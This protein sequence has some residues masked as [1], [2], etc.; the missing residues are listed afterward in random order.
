[1]RLICLSLAN[2]QLSEFFATN[3]GSAILLHFIQ[4]SAYCW[5]DHAL[6][7]IKEQLLTTLFRSTN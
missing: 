6:S 4:V 1:M 7:C 5:L 2:Q 3:T